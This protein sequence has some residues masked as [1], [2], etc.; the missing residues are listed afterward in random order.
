MFNM[1]KSILA[2]AILAGTL[3]LTACGGS[4]DSKEKPV[5]PINTAPSNITITLAEGQSFMGNVSGTN[6]GAL[7]ATDADSGDTLTFSTADEN[8][9]II[10]NTLVLKDDASISTDSIDVT[11]S[12]TDSVNTAVEETVTINVS[13]LSDYYGFNSKFLDNKSSVSYSGSRTPAVHTENICGI[14]WLH[15]SL[16]P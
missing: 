10:D 15:Y 3:G 6:A 8:F 9:D 14:D 7:S 16:P 2:T 13:Q 11:I 5:E 4:S 1:R 12:V